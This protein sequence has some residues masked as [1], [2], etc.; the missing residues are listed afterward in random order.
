LATD[1]LQQRPIQDAGVEARMVAALCEHLRA[2][3][4]PLDQ[5]QRL[6]LV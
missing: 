4:A 3:E 1:P 6:G 5:F 2:V